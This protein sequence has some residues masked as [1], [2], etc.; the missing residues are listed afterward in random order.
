MTPKS[1]LQER[2][3]KFFFLN[4]LKLT[5]V[6]FTWPFCQ[7]ASS[8]LSILNHFLILTKFKKKQYNMSEEEERQ[9]NWE[10]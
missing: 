6:Q 9:E 2:F 8:A 4:K 10:K 3:V 1:C 7:S 5:T